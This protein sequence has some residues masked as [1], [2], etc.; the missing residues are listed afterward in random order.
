MFLDADAELGRIEPDVR[1]VP[2]VL[3]V[4]VQIYSGLGNWKLMQ[5]VA[6]NLVGHDS[7]NIQ[8]IVWRAFAA[9]RAESLEAARSILLEA[10]ERHPEA[11]IL[12][13]N[14]A[15]YECQLGELE[16]AKARLRHAVKVEAAWRALAMEDEDLK[17]L[18]DSFGESL[19]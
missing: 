16:V 5:V 6:G 12:H 2:E 19:A 4:R 10:V 1:H 14:L 8:W 15:C 3:E 13:Y 9:R 18:W 17:P 7:A 11:A